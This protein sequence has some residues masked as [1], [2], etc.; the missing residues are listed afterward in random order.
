MTHRVILC[1]NIFIDGKDAGITQ[2]TR[3]TGDLETRWAT[4]H[5]FAMFG[6]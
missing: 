5:S 3:Y 6:K 2:V 4:R 1:I